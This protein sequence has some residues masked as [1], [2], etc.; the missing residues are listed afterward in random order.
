MGAVSTLPQSRPLTEA[1]LGLIREADDGHRYEL[2][3]GTLIV[4]PA[5][6]VVHQ[7]VVGELFVLLRGA[8]PPGLRV[9]TSPLDL[10]LARDTVLQ[11]D[12]MVARREDFTQTNLPV[13]PLLAVEVL[14]PS[15][16]H[17]DLALKRSRLEA[18]GAPAYWVIDPEGPSITVWELEHGAYRRAAHAVGAQAAILSRPF[19]VRVVPADLLDT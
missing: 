19:A 15:T 17:I 13:A 10:R 6:R 1:D 11:P 3:D 8:L 18:A 7:H 12:L 2:I 4:T 5:P 16:R 14:S 9:Y